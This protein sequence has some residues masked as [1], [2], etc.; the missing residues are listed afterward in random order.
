MPNIY[1]PESSVVARERIEVLGGSGTSILQNL[2]FECG[3]NDG[4]RTL[5]YVSVGPD[6]ASGLTFTS[7]GA[8]PAPAIQVSTTTYPTFD[9][10]T[11]DGGSFGW[12]SNGAIYGSSAPSG[13]RWTRMYLLNGSNITL[14]TAS[15]GVIQVAQA[16]GESIINWTP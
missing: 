13:V 1:F 9:R 12:N 8:T 5:N 10:I 2:T 16:T 7:V 6:F 3:A 4:Q 11:V 14:P 15:T